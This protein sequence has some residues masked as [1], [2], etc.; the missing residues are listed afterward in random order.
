MQVILFYHST[1]KDIYGLCLLSM[2]YIEE[3]TVSQKRDTADYQRVTLKRWPKRKN[4]LWLIYRELQPSVLPPRL[5]CGQPLEL[6]Q[7]L[8]GALVEGG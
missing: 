5:G 8:I 6:A 3:L 7:V 4:A 2:S 1:I